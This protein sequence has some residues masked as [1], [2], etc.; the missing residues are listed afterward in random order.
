M[1]PAETVHDN[2][3]SNK[4]TRQIVSALHT[5][6]IRWARFGCGSIISC[7]SEIVFSSNSSLSVV[8]TEA[9]SLKD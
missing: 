4:I 9:A 7:K 1:Q 3:I 2:K 5:K 6:Y 8:P